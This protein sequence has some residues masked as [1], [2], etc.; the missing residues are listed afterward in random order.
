MTWGQLSSHDFRQ[1][2]LP[3]AGMEA[4]GRA[5]EW[6][7]EPENGNT[8]F[9]SREARSWGFSMSNSG[10]RALPEWDSREV[11]RKAIEGGEVGFL[12]GS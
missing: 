2:Q 1:F 3:W 12:W 7:A 10:G 5:P 6:Q 11:G 9:L 8:E 4:R